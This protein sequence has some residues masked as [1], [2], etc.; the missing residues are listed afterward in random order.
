[1]SIS[2]GGRLR[3][4]L[5]YSHD[6][7]GLGHLRRNLAIASEMLRTTKQLQV[8][9][10]SGSPVAPR[11]PM[12]RGL[13]LV[14]L[15]SV[16][17]VAAEEYAAREGRVGFGIVSRARAA[18]MADVA[19]RFQP[20]ALLVDHAPQ[21]MKGELLPTFELLR[22][23]LPE[24]R[25]VLGLRD[26]LDDPATV[27]CSW[28]AQGV[29]ETL[30]QVYHRILVYGCQEILDVAAAYGIPARLRSRI[31]YCGYV[32][33]SSKPAEDRAVRDRGKLPEGPFVLGT[34]GGG[35]DGV[36]VLRATL[37][38]A[39]A[40]GAE[41]LLVTGPLMHKEIRDEL[42][43]EAAA[44][45]RARVVE[46]VT[47]LQR[48]MA[49]AAAIVTMGGYNTLCEAVASGV[50]TVVVPRTWP[51]R[52][53]AIRAGLFAER[54]LVRV[55]NPGDELAERLVLPLRAAMAQGGSRGTPIDLCGTQKVREALLDEVAR[56]WT[57][58]IV[59]PRQL[60]ERES[61]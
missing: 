42:A 21:G 36:A 23:C 12:P 35:E 7:Y 47:D 54:G 37:R 48:V 41:S 8:V 32:S 50:P 16:V 44:S 29:L 19:L 4:L 57:R 40:L 58:R 49:C 38:A 1:M 52:E 34:A 18:I 61:A 28:H 53:Q 22:Q 3:R 31:S 15:P 33:R 45:G 39:Q 43:A 2:P 55:V 51:R 6:T 56:P 20:D 30:E 17:K 25:I 9:L 59:V 26:V 24:T 11:F 27:R 5:L 10:M 60:R 13:S 14:S 46:F